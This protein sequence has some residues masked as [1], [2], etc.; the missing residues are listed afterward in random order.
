MSR[1]DATLVN[2]LRAARLAVGFPGEPRPSR[3]SGRSQDPVIGNPPVVGVG[4]AVKR[5][6]TDFRGAHPEIPWKQIAGMRDV[7][8]H[9]YDEVDVIE[10]WNAVHRE[11]PELITALEALAGDTG[12]AS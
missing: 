3:L 9:S 1:D 8:M 12:T 4:E 5:L 11:I 6:S 2:L 10:V 7:M